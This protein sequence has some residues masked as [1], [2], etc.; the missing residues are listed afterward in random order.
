MKRH[1]FVVAGIAA[2][3]LLL[4]LL[5][6]RH[7]GSTSR[8]T[9]SE[10][11]R[12]ELVGTNSSSKV[13]ASSSDSPSDDKLA[14]SAA[15]EPN[16]RAKL[17]QELHDEYN[18]TQNVPVAFYCLVV[19]QNSNTVQNVSVELEVLEQY[20]GTSPEVTDKPTN[21]KKVTGSDGRF[22]IIGPIGHTVTV[23]GFSKDGYEPERWQKHYG[24]YGA[25]STSFEKPAILNLWSTNAHETLITGEKR[26]RMVPD[27]RH[28]GV[29]LMKGTMTDGDDGDLVV[30]IKRPEALKP[31]EKY[32]WSC[33]LDAANGLKQETDLNSP[34]SRAPPDGYTNAFTFQV[35]YNTR[36]RDGMSF[37]NRFYFR[38]RNSDWFGRLSVDFWTHCREDP[39]VGLIKVSYAINPS[40]SRLLW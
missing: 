1:L 6:P 7:D 5:W 4:V 30:W 37:D 35:E 2:L 25:R 32:G 15:I 23:L 24:I 38:M 14:A 10:S 34:M 20:L 33:G 16:D 22:E 40:K 28:Y 18:R 31:T 39:S 12:T 17:I 36:A 26:F 9:I 3:L 29:D 11:T 8:P 19:D 21:M 27:G 13:R